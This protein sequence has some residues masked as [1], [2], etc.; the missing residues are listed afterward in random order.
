MLVSPALLLLQRALGLQI[1]RQNSSSHC[2]LPRSYYD[3]RNSSPTPVSPRSSDP[4]PPPTQ[5][6]IWVH[7]K[8]RTLAANPILPLLGPLPL[9]MASPISCHYRLVNCSTQ[10]L[11]TIHYQSLSQSYLATAGFSQSG[12]TTLHICNTFRT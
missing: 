7:R 1:L 2:L 9:R 5:S 12:Q 11:P 6:S 10:A 8:D 4:T 3:H